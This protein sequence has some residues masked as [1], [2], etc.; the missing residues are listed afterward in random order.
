[1]EI[2]KNP[3]FEFLALRDKALKGSLTVILI[4]ILSLILHGGPRWGI[5]F[6]GGAAITFKFDQ[7]IKAEDVREALRR[8]G[9]ESY[10]VTHF[11]DERHLL[12]R[13]KLA[14]SKQDY[15]GAIQ[16]QLD[17]M[18]RKTS[19]LSSRTTWWARKSVPS[20]ERKP[21]CHCCFL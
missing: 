3:N 16:S 2:I 14:H 15:L 21:F 20:S 19:I 8:A 17:S 11:G 5:D 9:M 7:E 12:V 18:F 4:G 6:T 13:L 1:M 10:E